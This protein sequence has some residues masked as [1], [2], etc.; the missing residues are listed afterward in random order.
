M[1]HFRQHAGHQY[2]QSIEDENPSVSAAICGLCGKKYD[3]DL[4]E[5]SKC[6]VNLRRSLDSGV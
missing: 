2:G 5:W 3:M 1:S 6:P 4:D